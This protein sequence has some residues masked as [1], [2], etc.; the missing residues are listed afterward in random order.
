MGRMIYV[1]DGHNLVP[2]LPGLSLRAL[3]DEQRLVALLQVFARVRRHKV[4]VFFDGAPPGQSG[5]RAFGSV[6]A[7]FVRA[8][9]TA[10]DAIRT[11]LRR[12]GPR[13]A[14][15]TVVSSDRQ[16]RAEAHAL[17]ASLLDSA[18][19][20]AELLRAQR[21]NPAGS[22]REGGETPNPAEIDEWLRLMGGNKSD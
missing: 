1:V 9:R 13:A 15:V 4:E 3:D 7:H 21:E 19:F 5:P 11:Y 20:A 17:R 14:Q 18:A 12:L 8:G 22:G 6:K 10:D 16:V 2:H